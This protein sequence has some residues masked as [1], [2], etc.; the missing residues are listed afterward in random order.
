MLTMLLYLHLQYNLYKKC[1]KCVMLK[2]CDDYS[3]MFNIEKYQLLH[4]SN[5]HEVIKGVRLGY[6]VIRFV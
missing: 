2:M 4:Y 5:N 6:L 3:A 1:K